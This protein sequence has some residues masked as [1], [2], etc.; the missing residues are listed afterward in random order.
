MQL[1]LRSR[2]QPNPR[3]TFFYTTKS[4]SA[5]VTTSVKQAKKFKSIEEIEQ[6]FLQ[7][8]D[9]LKEAK[10]WKRWY[11]V[12]SVDTATNELTNDEWKDIRL[13]NY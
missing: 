1:V 10:N 12:R 13:G 3:N 11:V 4:K 9:D 5:E 6:Y 8:P 2:V 7:L